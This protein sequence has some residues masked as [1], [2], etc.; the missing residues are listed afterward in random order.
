MM[1]LECIAGRAPQAL[2][3]SG[4]LI[5]RHAGMACPRSVTIWQV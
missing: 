2:Q 5:L 4:N 3:L 1:P